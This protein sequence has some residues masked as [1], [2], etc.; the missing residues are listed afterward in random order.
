MAAHGAT[1][2]VLRERMYPVS[3]PTSDRTFA[4]PPK[5][6]AAPSQNEGVTMKIIAKVIESMLSKDATQKWN[7]QTSAFELNNTWHWNP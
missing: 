1:L 5:M 3:K 2:M 4:S 6:H 7:G